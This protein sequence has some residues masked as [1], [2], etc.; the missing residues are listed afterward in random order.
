[1]ERGI[2][3]GTEIRKLFDEKSISKVWAD[4]KHYTLNLLAASTGMRM[5]ELQALPVHAV[6]DNYVEVAQSWERRD[7]IKSGTK[8]G[9]G[10][11]VPLPAVTSKHLRELIASSPYQES[12]DLVF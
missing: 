12:D 8:T 3:T 7:G 6:H 4:R 11:V 5:G 9:A 10:R 1:M 2:L